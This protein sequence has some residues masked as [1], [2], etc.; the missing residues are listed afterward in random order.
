M[1]KGMGEEIPQEKKEKTQE[2]KT[3]GKS[4]AKIK[5]SGSGTIARVDARELDISGSGKITGPVNVTSLSVSGSAKVNGPIN[6]EGSIHVSGSLRAYND[7]TAEEVISSGF[8]RMRNC[9]CNL[10]SL[11]GMADL[12]GAL[13]SDKIE[14]SGTLRAKSI[15]CHDLN[16]NGIVRTDT[17]EGDSIEV[18]GSVDGKQVKAKRFE[19]EAVSLSS[20]ITNLEAEKIKITVRRR[21]IFPGPVVS[22][23]K[24]IG[25]NVSLEGV[26][27]AKVIAEK[28]VI[29]DHC[30]IDYV[31][32]ET[33]SVSEKSSVIEQK[34]MP[35]TGNQ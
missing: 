17:L 19:L 14:E 24:I 32:A 27:C 9:K 1:I 16:F 35:R 31:E 18:H 11:T 13:S 21:V 34:I 8:V 28:V 3:T 29:R 23:D 5:I 33:I 12:D 15:K 22:L 20:G 10:F 2:P 7:V 26:R 6:C 4:D 30:N 25:K